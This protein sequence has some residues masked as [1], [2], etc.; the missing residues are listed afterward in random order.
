V[1]FGRDGL[2]QDL[3]MQL[4]GEPLDLQGWVQLGAL[5]LEGE[6]EGLTGSVVVGVRLGREAQERDGR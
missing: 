2:D 6:G 5:E 3:P 4:D 1:G